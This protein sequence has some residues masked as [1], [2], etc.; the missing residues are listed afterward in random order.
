M[1]WN[2]R[3]LTSCG[4]FLDWISIHEYWDMIH[5]TN[6]CADYEASMV[7][8]NDIGHSVRKVRGLLEA[9]GLE[10]QIRIAFDK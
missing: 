9:L 10:K 8:T 2:I 7:Y 4:S 5:N 6:D 3:L 1:D